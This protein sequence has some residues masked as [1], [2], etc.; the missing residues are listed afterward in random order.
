M[1][2]SPLPKTATRIIALAMLCAVGGCSQNPYYAAPGAAAWQV[3]PATVAVSPSEAQIS[4][5]SRRVQL[6]GRQQPPTPHPIGPERTE[7]PSL[8]R[9]I[10]AAATPVGRCLP[11]T[12]DRHGSRRVPRKR[13]S[14]GCRRRLNFVAG[15]RS[16]PTPD[17]RCRPRS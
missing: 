5:L 2:A 1:A 8:Q 13:G 6:L 10:G 9:R 11:A 7:E 12:R 4:E 3:P 17:Y 16:P 14:A 15:R